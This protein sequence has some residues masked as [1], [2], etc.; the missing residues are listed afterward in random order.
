MDRVRGFYRKAILKAQK[1]FRPP[2]SSKVLRA[3][4]VFDPKV[5]FTTTLDDAKDKFKTVASKFSNVVKFLDI[6][7]LL[8]QVTSLHAREDVKKFS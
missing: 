5:L 3:C 7:K 6:P 4:D 8:D 2:L 1:Y